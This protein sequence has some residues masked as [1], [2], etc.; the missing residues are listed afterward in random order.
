M[1]PF[2]RPR[3]RP[4]AW[5]TKAVTR[6]ALEFGHSHSQLRRSDLSVVTSPPQNLRSR[7]RRS[8]PSGGGPALR[9]RAMFIA[10]I[11]SS[12]RPPLG[13]PCPSVFQANN[14]G[15][16][17]LEEHMTLLPRAWSLAI[18]GDSKFRFHAQSQK[19]TG[20]E[21]GFIPAPRS[22]FTRTCRTKRSGDR[23]LFPTRDFFMF[24][25]PTNFSLTRRNPK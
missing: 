9:R 16:L 3:G 10:G 25:E 20:R 4:P 12:I 8:T 19:I 15:C 5:T 18:F 2:F 7:F 11:G 21:E 14:N 22:W 24:G 6:Q 17:H 1:S 23:S 13:G